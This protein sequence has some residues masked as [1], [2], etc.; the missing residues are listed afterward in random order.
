MEIIGVSTYNGTARIA[1]NLVV[2]AAMKRERYSRSGYLY[3]SDAFKDGRPCSLFGLLP[4][5]QFQFVSI[6]LSS[7][8]SETL[9]NATY[10]E[11]RSVT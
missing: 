6:D 7:G 11:R 4:Y 2:K 5:F 10:S 3:L 1:T 8:L 9:K